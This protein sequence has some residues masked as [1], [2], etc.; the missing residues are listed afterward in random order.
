V[1]P[2]HRRQGIGTALVRR[3]VR[4]TEA[5]GVQALHLY[6]PD[7][8]SFYARLGWSVIERPEYRGYPQVVMA[9]PITGRAP[10]T[11]QVPDSAERP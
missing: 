3:V 8:E 5:L 11:S 7:K 2:E 10:G 9:L 1:A 4:E 6:T